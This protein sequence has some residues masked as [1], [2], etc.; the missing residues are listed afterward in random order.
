[1]FAE[2]AGDFVPP[3]TSREGTTQSDLS[4]RGTEAAASGG[5]L[6]EMLQ[7]EL[8]LS[9]HE[10]HVAGFLSFRRDHQDRRY[11]DLCPCLYV[12]TIAVRHRH[13]RCGIARALYQRLFDLPASMPPWVVLRTWSTNTDHLGVIDRLGFT[14]ILR[15]ED[16]RLPGVDTLYLATDR[17]ARVDD[18]PSPPQGALVQGSA[19]GAA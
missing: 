19:E 16:D 9:R 11:A 7:Q 8:I 1:M 17:T 2:V 13:R 14:T 4:E 6:K 3:L 10:G 15:L 18:V 12:S 5:Y